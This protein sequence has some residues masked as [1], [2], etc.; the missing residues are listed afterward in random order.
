MR[1]TGRHSS[2]EQYQDILRVIPTWRAFWALQL[3]L[4]DLA[5]Q[6]RAKE[7][8]IVTGNDTSNGHPRVAFED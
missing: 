6:F 7:E 1:P 8:H 3:Y 2:P 5:G 4:N